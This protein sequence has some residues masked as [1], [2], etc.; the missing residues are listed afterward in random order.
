MGNGSFNKESN[1]ETWSI[2]L[3]ESPNFHVR[4]AVGLFSMV[5]LPQ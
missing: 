3:D 4:M 1:L 5:L 2:L